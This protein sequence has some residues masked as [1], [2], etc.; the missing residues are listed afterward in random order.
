MAHISGIDRSQ[1]LLLPERV[2]D[3]VG[4]EN[5][6]RFVDGFFAGL[7]AI[8]ARV[9]G[10]ATGRL[11]YHPADL[12]KLYIYG[13]LNRVGSSPCLEVKCGRNLEVV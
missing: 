3:Y 2:E 6:V 12:L 13:Y 1:V 11:D 4:A 9:Q 10:E 8:F 7:A 5:S